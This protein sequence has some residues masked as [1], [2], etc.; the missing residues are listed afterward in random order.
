MPVEVLISVK[1]KGVE[2]RSKKSC[3]IQAIEIIFTVIKMKLL[4]LL[5]PLKGRK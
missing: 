1:Y 4:A 3:L 2:H 5:Y